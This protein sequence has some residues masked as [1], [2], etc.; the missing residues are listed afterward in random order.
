M[1]LIIRSLSTI[2]HVYAHLYT[3]YYR[4]FFVYYQIIGSNI[5]LF[6]MSGIFAFLI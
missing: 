6:L 3:V 5:H 1:Y 4:L 2:L